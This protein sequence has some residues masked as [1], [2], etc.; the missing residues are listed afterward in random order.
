MKKTLVLLGVLTLSFSMGFLS[1]ASTSAKDTG[2]AKEIRASADENNL[3][4][5]ARQTKIID[6]QDRTIGAKQN[7]E[8]LLAAKNG[9]G[10]LYTRMYGLSDEYVNHKWFV[11]AAQN[12]ALA[13]AETE[14]ETE[15]LQRLGQEM[16]NTINSTI[17]TELTN[18]QKSSIRTICS[19]VNNVTLNG[20]GLRTTYWQLEQTKDEYGNIQELYNF[21]A[22][23]SCS[24]DTYNRL[25]NM[26]LI[27]LLQSKDLD[28]GSIS[29]I[30]KHAQEIL[31]DAN[32]TSE[33]IAEAK[34]REWINQMNEEETARIMAREETL[35]QQSAN[36]AEAAANASPFTTVKM[37]N[38]GNAYMNP[39]LSALI[40][41]EVN[42]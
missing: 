1:C 32:E 19:K 3:I 5:E 14:A 4:V 2:V 11:S 7:P 35:R 26:Y 23:Y 24:T 37:E 8:W 30:K 39:A 27:T 28:E 20:I 21:Y 15:V 33:R 18:G 17:G 42:K 16:A 10:S 13:N 29:S 40:A 36:F 31:N 25:L 6:W 12:R 38:A 22:V 9:N 41:A 34:K